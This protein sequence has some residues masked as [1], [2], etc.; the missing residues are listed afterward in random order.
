MRP[1]QKSP[2]GFL[3]PLGLFYIRLMYYAKSDDR[4]S[5][6][7]KQIGNM[8][9]TIYGTKRQYYLPLS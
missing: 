6:I 8:K 2:G 1:M 5:E 9:S 7:L 3:F 4:L